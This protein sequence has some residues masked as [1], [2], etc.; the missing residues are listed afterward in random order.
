MRKA[1]TWANAHHPD[2]AR[3]LATALNKPVDEI[4]AIQ[5]VPYITHL[6]P[7]LIQ[8]SIDLA[9]RYGIIKAPFPAADILDRAAR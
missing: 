4:D 7:A 5:R 3:I 6:T 1:A 8:S 2:S 9:A